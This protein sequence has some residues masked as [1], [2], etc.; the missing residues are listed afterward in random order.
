LKGLKHFVGGMTIEEIEPFPIGENP[1]V[2]DFSNM[3]QHLGNN[4][5]AFMKNFDNEPMKWLVLLDQTTGRRI[6]ISFDTPKG[7]DNEGF[8]MD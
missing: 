4:V 2:S 6:K 1:A 8:S 3:F 5:V 7:N